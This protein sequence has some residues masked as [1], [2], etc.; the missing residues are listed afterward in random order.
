MVRSLRVRLNT[1]H[2]MYRQEG[3]LPL[4]SI[5]TVLLPRAVEAA[6]GLAHGGNAPF[7]PRNARVHQT[8]LR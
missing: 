6:L 7:T 2:R 3:T 4:S 5:G 8:G 1:P